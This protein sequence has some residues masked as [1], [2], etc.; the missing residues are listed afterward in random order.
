MDPS[1]SQSAPKGDIKGKGRQGAQKRKRGKHQPEALAKQA[2]SI[3]QTT[4]IPVS[5]QQAV[6]PSAEGARPPKSLSRIQDKKLRSHLSRQHL[7]Q[8]RAAE[9]A[10]LADEYLNGPA[11]GEEAGFIVPEG[12]LERTH[13]VTQAEIKENVGIEVARK[14]FELRLD[15]G[16]GGVGL[17]PYRS[18]YTRNGRHLLLGGRKGHLAAF[19]WQA[20]KLLCEI[21]VKETV[22]DVKWLHNSSFFAAAQKKYVYIYDQQGV[23]IHRLKQHIEVQRM[24]FLPYHFLLATVVSSRPT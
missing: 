8:R 20:G 7:S 10:A 12:P 4:R 17:G 13:R 24:E 5:L 11:P 23:E 22:R 9:H 1:S 2:D 14:G 19:D 18:D 3:A 15:G 21:Q 6:P 16:A